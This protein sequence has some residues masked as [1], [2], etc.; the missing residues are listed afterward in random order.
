MKLL[1]KLFCGAAFAI[2]IWQ[3][4]PYVSW[5]GSAATFAIDGNSSGN[6]SSRQKMLIILFSPVTIIG[7]TF[8]MMGC[9][10]STV[11]EIYK[12]A[13]RPSIKA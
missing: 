3:M 5:D 10:I 12:W 11:A 6:G 9:F 7:L 13:S 2:L 8:A 4:S 1:I